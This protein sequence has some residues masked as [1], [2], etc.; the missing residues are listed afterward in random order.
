MNQQVGAKRS[1]AMPPM[2]AAI[3]GATTG[4]LPNSSS[5]RSSSTPLRR[6]R[7]TSSAAAATWV[8]IAREIS[9]WLFEW[10]P[11]VS[12]QSLHIIATRTDPWSV[13]K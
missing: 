8:N 2:A 10:D 6:R 13:Q 9:K 12:P 3:G 4:R 7:C 5:Q 1:A 11:Q